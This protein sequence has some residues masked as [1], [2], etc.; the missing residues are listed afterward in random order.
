MPTHAGRH[1]KPTAMQPDTPRAMSRTPEEDA[2]FP[3]AEIPPYELLQTD[4]QA[5]GHPQ[6]NVS[7]PEEECEFPP[8]LSVPLDNAR[9]LRPPP[10]KE[11]T[12]LRLRFSL[13]KVTLFRMTLITK[14]NSSTDLFW[15]P[16]IGPPGNLKP[17][18]LMRSLH[19][20][21]S[22]GAPTYKSHCRYA[23]CPRSKSKSRRP[24]CQTIYPQTRHT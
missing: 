11:T 16:S 4:R 8:K 14:V 21:S 17:V 3:R 13:S 18:L 6:G 1:V 12:P 10:Q 15:A 19:C 9:M 24:A 22:T 23:T 2:S 5:A 7:N 20:S